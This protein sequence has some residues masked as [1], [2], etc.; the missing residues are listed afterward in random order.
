MTRT[1]YGQT[2]P[3]RKELRRLL[4]QFAE[5]RTVG[6]LAAKFVTKAQ[7]ITYGVTDL[8]YPQPIV[9]GILREL[10]IQHQIRFREEETT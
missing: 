3:Q 4:I 2:E 6:P 1:I 10:D 5:G 7:L 9:E 8:G